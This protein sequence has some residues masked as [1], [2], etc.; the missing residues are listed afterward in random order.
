M[1]AYL[2]TARGH[3][4]K[5]NET[6]QNAD[7]NVPS[8]RPDLHPPII[9]F[10]ILRPE[11]VTPGYIFLAP[12]RNIDPGPYIYDNDG[13]L[14]WSG[15][16]Y[17]GPRTA[18]A[19]RVGQYKGKDVL[20]YYTGQQHQG[21]AR[22]HGVIMDQSYRTIKTVEASGAG[23]SS[24]MHEFRFT[25]HSDGTSALLTV[26]QPRQYDLTTNP[27]FNVKGGMGWVVEGVFQEIEIDTGRLI[28]EWR[29]LD[30]IDPGE[31][32]TLPSG[33][34]TSGDGLHEQ[35]PWDYFHL[36]SIDKNQEGDYL[37]SA[38]HVSALYRLS[39]KDGSI[40]WQMGGANPSFEQTNFVFSYQH[41]V[42]WV[43]ENSTHEVISF[44]DNGS[45]TFNSTA[46]FSH[47]WIIV[48]DKQAQ[49]ATKTMEWGAPEPEGGLMSG[50]QGNMQLLPNGGCH[51]GWGEHSYFSEHLADGTCVQYGKLALRASNVMIYR[52]NKYNWTALPETKPALWTYSKFGTIGNRD[53]EQK[54][55]FYVSWNGATEVRSWNFYTSDSPS[56]PW[57]FVASENK[58]GFETTHRSRAYREWAYAEALDAQDRVLMDSVIARTFVPSP[59]LRK[60]CGAG[61]CDRSR[62]VRKEDNDH[63]A[64]QA[65]IDVEEQY[66]S[67]NRGF[68]TT[69]YYRD[70][71][72]EKKSEQEVI[73]PTHGGDG[74][75]TTSTTKPI[76]WPTAPN[77]PDSTSTSNSSSG[78][79]ISSSLFLMVVGMIMG[80]VLSIFLR[81]L[82]NNGAFRRFEPVVDRFNNSVSTRIFGF[83]SLGKYHR[84]REKDMDDSQA[85]SSS[86]ALPL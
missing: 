1:F 42:R 64:Y 79:Y 45:N 80:F 19:P 74:S 35:S 34:D 31:A 56:G 70:E 14:V 36:N 11:L 61:F 71:D 76:P 12:Y 55:V 78:S 66:L 53:R 7:Q 83:K 23:A 27:R 38:R 65:H 82:Y 32:W 43:S 6:K 58:T 39:G 77:D 46:Q 52:S 26:Y 21:F 2:C 16:G 54:M 20:Y 63:V 37:I 25:P 68:N 28:F 73:T 10:Q 85:G 51:I 44:Y 40:M 48:I 5:G 49:T 15:A 3:C 86:S 47:G 57:E 41:H 29:S 62:K 67:P 30:H 9:N 17:S 24:D 22:G 81:F 75:T 50:S 72:A 8:Q 4:L 33:S 59:G 13:N 84:V 69:H 18:H 60:H